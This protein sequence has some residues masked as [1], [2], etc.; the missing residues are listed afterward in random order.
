MFSKVTVPGLQQDTLRR[1]LLNNTHDMTEINGF[2]CK[3]V[4]DMKTKRTNWDGEYEK[5]AAL[6]AAESVLINFLKNDKK[7]SKEATVQALRNYRKTLGQYELKKGNTCEFFRQTFIGLNIDGKGTGSGVLKDDNGAVYQ[8]EYK[9]G[10]PHGRGTM[11]Y[12]NK[13]QYD[14]MWQHGKRH[15]RGIMTYANKDQYDGMWL[16]D[17]ANGQGVKT[18]TD[19]EK[20]D[21]LW[22]N[23]VAHGRGVLTNTN[24]D[25]YV[26]DFEHG[27]RHGL[28]AMRYASGNQY[29][30]GWRGGKLHGQGTMKCASGEQYTG[31]WQ[32]G[33]AHGQG[34]MKYANGDIYEGVW[35][36][37][38]RQE[39]GGR[40]DSKVTKNSVNGK[41]QTA[42]TDTPAENKLVNRNTKGYGLKNDYYMFEL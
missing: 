8:G 14:G 10:K 21:G 33:V 31:S 35:H 38:R 2:L 13:N 27:K 19:G 29:N 16:E 30:G 26:G 1:Y 23:G 9:D 20:Y 41:P 5:K 17:K 22:L 34:S 3:I 18:Y 12:A 7:L 39:Q 15:G 37:G 40:T 6:F 32:D 28:G 36:C 24:G 42:S 11:K 25:I 4:E